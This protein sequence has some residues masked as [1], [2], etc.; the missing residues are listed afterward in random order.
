[1]NKISKLSE[2]DKIVPTVAHGTDNKLYKILTRFYKKFMRN[3]SI[4]KSI[5]E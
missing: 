4:R 5:Y 1:M 3:G 2:F